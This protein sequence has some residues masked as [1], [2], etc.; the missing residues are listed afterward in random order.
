MRKI[1]EKPF[2]PSLEDYPVLIITSTD[3]TMM[4]IYLRLQPTTKCKN[5]DEG[6]KTYGMK[7]SCS[8]RTST[9]SLFG[10]GG[11]ER[12]VRILL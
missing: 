8:I 3:E 5:F 4:S 2:I 6:D 11:D 1:A 7:D 12:L 9:P 10:N